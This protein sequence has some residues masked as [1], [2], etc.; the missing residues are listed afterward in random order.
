MQKSL[1]YPFA[2]YISE[3]SKRILIE[4]DVTFGAKSC[5]EILIFVYTYIL[6]KT[7]KIKIICPESKL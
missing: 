5:V 7:F 2:S 4:P 1:V 6:Y 3:I